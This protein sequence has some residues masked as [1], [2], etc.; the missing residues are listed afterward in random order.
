MYKSYFSLPHLKNNNGQY[1]GALY[2]FIKN[3]MQITQKLQ[4]DF[5]IFAQDT[6]EKTFRHNA[7]AQY[8]ANRAPMEEAMLTQI[9]PVNDVQRLISENVFA[10]VGYE[11]DDIIYSLVNDNKDKDA[12]FYIYSADKDLYQLFVFDNVYFINQDKDYIT[13]FGRE[14]FEK[15]YLL[16][17]NQWVEYKALVGDTGDN[18][19]GVPGIGAVGAVNI[20]HHCENLFTLCKNIGL[21][22]GKYNE[23][24]VPI[25]YTQTSKALSFV[26]SPKNKKIIEKVTTNEQLLYHSYYLSKLVQFDYFKTNMYKLSTTGLTN[27]FDWSAVIETLEKNNMDSLIKYYKTNFANQQSSEELF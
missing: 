1:T 22:S 20:L 21:L 7:D 2:G 6:K 8:K 26:L 14:D 13:T 11:A 4:P 15:K 17:P 10:C 18:F 23:V 5:L 25:D 19:A 16:K 12:I 9:A 27:G 24:F 3:L